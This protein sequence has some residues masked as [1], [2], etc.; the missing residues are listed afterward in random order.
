MPVVPLMHPLMGPQVQEA[1]QAVLSNGSRSHDGPHVAVWATSLPDAL[2]EAMHGTTGEQ[3]RGGGTYGLAM[4]VTSEAEAGD[5]AGRL[6]DDVDGGIE[7]MGST[8]GPALLQAVAAYL[9]D[10]QAPPIASLTADCCTSL[11]VPP[12]TSSDFTGSNMLQRHGSGS[13]SVQIVEEGHAGVPLA[14]VARGG[15]YLILLSNFP[16]T[17]AL[18]VTLVGA[19]SRETPLGMPVTDTSGA[20]QV[21]WAVP[22]AMASGPYYVQAAPAPVAGRSSEDGATGMSPALQVGPSCKVDG[23]Q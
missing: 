14:S 2:Q 10:H 22:R 19:E 15:R 8:E 4:V 5:I 18:A 23:T 13:C 12:Y 17:L 21:V 20:A 11:F 6:S 3:A 9:Q 1:L 7:D 16:A